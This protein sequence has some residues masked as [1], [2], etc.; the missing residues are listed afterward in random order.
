MLILARKEE[1]V[2]SEYREANKPANQTRLVGGVCIN[3]TLREGFNSTKHSD[4]PDIELSDWWNVPYI[5]ECAYEPSDNSYTEYVK[6]ITTVGAELG[7]EL[8]EEKDWLL[9]QEGNL[10][11]FLSSYPLGFAYQVRMIDGG[12]WDR[13]SLIGTYASLE[14]ALAL[15]NQI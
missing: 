5:L 12:C 9:A 6:R 11:S 13:S 4:R 15:V 10:G 8:Q 1:E 14:E 7:F 3:P 2:M